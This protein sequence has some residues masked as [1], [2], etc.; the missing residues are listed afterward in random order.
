M[1]E[2]PRPWV[3]VSNPTKDGTIVLLRGNQ[4]A[5]PVQGEWKMKQWGEEIGYRH[6]G[7]RS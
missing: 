6:L 7:S 5:W 1:V 4:P 2:S 3:L